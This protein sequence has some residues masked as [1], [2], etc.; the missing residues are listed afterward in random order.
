MTEKIQAPYANL[1]K[2]TD[3]SNKFYTI[4]IQKLKRGEAIIGQE[5]LA[6]QDGFQIY[7][8]FGKKT[9]NKPIIA[10]KGIFFTEMAAKRSAKRLKESKLQKGYVTFKDTIFASTV[11]LDAPDT[12][13]PNKTIDESLPIEALFQE[14][15]K[16]KQKM[17][18]NQKNRFQNLVE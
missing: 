9:A 4:F 15:P 18:T 17:T 11:V 8:F 14:L 13:T 5:K 7:T 10:H 1:H 6:S 16:A 2:V 3:G 12:R